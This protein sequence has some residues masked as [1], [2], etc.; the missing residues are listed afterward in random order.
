LTC[1]RGYGSIDSEQKVEEGGTIMDSPEEESDI[2]ENEED[3]AAEERISITFD[4]SPELY[5]IIE[6]AA[7]E[8]ALSISEYLER[9]VEE[10]VSAHGHPV[11]LEAIE[12]LRHLREQIFQENNEQFFEDSAELL[13]QQREERTRELGGL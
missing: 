3:Q 12:R 7:V 8:E 1:R 6:A 9:I 11:T 5:A 13:H 10:S 4:I 2:N